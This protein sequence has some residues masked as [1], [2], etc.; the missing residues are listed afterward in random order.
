MLVDLRNP[1]DSRWDFTSEQCEAARGLFAV[2]Q[3]DLGITPDVVAE[4]SRPVVGKDYWSEME[5]IALRAGVSI[6]A[7][8]TGNLYYDALKAVLVGCT[9]F[10]VDTPKGPLHA[11][12][13]DWWSENDA[14]HRHTLQTE[15]IGGQAGRFLTVAWPGADSTEGEC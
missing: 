14:L 10:A 3:R 11:R 8:V 12:N 2:Y 6:E 7:V 5:G 1:A 13:L 15:F 9:A 4:L